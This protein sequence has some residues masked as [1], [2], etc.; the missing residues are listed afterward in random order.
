MPV[1]A[2]L[3]LEFIEHQTSQCCEI[4]WGSVVSR[5]QHCISYTTVK[6]VFQAIPGFCFEP[7]DFLHILKYIVLPEPR[8]YLEVAPSLGPCALKYPVKGRLL[9]F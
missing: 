5:F 8:L 9:P 3:P 6:D 2:V 7:E 1:M 4:W